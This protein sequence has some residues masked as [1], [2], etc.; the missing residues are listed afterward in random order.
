MTRRDPFRVLATKIGGR[1]TR[2]IVFNANQG[3]VERREAK[4]KLKNYRVRVG[5]APSRLSL[6]I[7]G[8]ETSVAFA[9]GAPDKICV[10]NRALK[11][12]AP[13][14]TVRVYCARDL[15]PNE[16]RNWLNNPE[17]L[18][19]LQSL[20]CSK[21]EPLHVYRNGI[22]LLADPSRATPARLDLLVEFADRLP[23]PRIHYKPG[24]LRIDGLTL[25]PNL[26]PEDLQELV[27]YVQRWA[28]GDDV[29][30]QER[31]AQAKRGELAKLLKLAGPLLGRIDEYLNSFGSTPLPIEAMLIG[32]LAEA[33]AELKVGRA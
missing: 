5:E 8:F 20:S 31:L 2:C 19:V 18:S 14:V 17:N 9:V 32:Q 33:V 30:R 6:E 16:A 27:P 26:L 7:R 29:E 24:Q 22:T 12:P 3:E 10:M 25:D 4:G 15:A 13:L 1:V 11:L 21:R 23:R 28:V